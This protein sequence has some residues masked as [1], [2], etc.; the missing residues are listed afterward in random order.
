MPRRGRVQRGQ[1]LGGER[2]VKSLQHGSS[3]EE[4]D[5]LSDWA[6]RARAFARLR[7]IAGPGPHGW[8]MLPRSNRRD[9]NG[10][11]DNCRDDGTVIRSV[12]AA[13]AGVMLCTDR[14]YM[15]SEHISPIGSH[16]RDCKGHETCGAIL[17]AS[18]VKR[19]GG[20]R[21]QRLMHSV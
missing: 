16:R 6:L 21:G 14:L 1:A 10:R 4:A 5:D 12:P 20:R 19:R 18:F 15:F 17:R 9:A 3:F 8:A 7:G 13:V 2:N 11:D